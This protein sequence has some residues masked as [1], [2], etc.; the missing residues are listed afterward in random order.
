M[1]TTTP[2]CDQVTTSMTHNEPKTTP[3]ESCIVFKERRYLSY[4]DE[5]YFYAWLE[6]IEGVEKVTGIHA[7]LLRV[8]L[9]SPF[10]TR[11]GA[12]DLIALF[13]RYSYPLLPIRD[14]IA[15]ADLDYFKK[16]DARWHEALFGE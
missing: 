12:F 1:A 5:K 16:P 13:T 4:Y 3:P 2:M 7:G 9:N 15:P 11:S 10:L 8:D 14:H 6:S